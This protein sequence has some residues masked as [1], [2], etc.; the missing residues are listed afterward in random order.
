MCLTVAV[1]IALAFFSKNYLSER[2]Q[3][4]LGRT[5]TLILATAVV[6]WILI[7]MA[8]GEFDYKTD[9][10]FDVC[11]MTALLLPFLMW[12]PR[13]RV[14]EILYFWIFGGTL[15]AILTP[16]LFEGFPHFTFVKYW[17]VHGGLIVFA[18]YATVVF[19]LFPTW[20][21]LL[22]AFVGFQFYLVFVFVI[23]LILDS[24]YVYIMGKPP[25]A[26][27]LD[28]MGDYPWYILSGEVAALFIF[29]IVFLPVY[30]ATKKKQ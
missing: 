26:S 13:H 23:N 4:Q 21:S 5:M 29:A 27:A 30:F 28:Y 18:V 24:N 1:S 3:I 25:T 9:L 17:L 11:N 16:H 14:H 20:R 19:R 2:R 12:Q 15:Q 7:R 22:R 10:P 6:G 8:R